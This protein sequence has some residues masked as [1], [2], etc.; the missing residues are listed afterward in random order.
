MP[1]DIVLPEKFTPSE[2]ISRSIQLIFQFI[3]LQLNLY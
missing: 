3:Y 1:K 2:I